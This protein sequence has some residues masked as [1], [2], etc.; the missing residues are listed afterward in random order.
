MTSTADICRRR[1]PRCRVPDLVP[2]HRDDER[3]G[4]GGTLSGSPPADP[5]GLEGHEAAVPEACV[6]AA[7]RRLRN[8]RRVG[9]SR[10]SVLSVPSVT[11]SEIRRLVFARISGDTTPA[12]RWVASRRWMP[13][14]RPALGDVDQPGHEL[15]Q[16]RAIGELVD[17]DE[18]PR[19]AAA[20]PAPVRSS[21]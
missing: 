9:A 13:R 19:H 6:A 18:Q 8:A 10:T 16:L 5:T 12:G 1:F 11:R 17:D 2:A 7:R 21:T 15:R 20:A 3:L 4:R 14:D